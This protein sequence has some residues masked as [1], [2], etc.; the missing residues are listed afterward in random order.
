MIH[1][2]RDTYLA[3]GD[4]VILMGHQGDMPNFGQRSTLKQQMRY[5][6]G[7]DSLGPVSGFAAA[8]LRG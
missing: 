3:K 7:E 5:R 6:G 4:T 2:G 8:S 1:P